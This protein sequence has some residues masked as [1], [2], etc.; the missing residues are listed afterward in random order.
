MLIIYYN[1]MNPK[2]KELIYHKIM[3]EYNKILLKKIMNK[4]KL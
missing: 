4:I 1:T 2:I 3:E